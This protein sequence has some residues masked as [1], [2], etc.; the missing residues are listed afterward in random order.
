MKMDDYRS[1]KKSP[2][3]STLGLFAD[4]LTPE[5][6]AYE[7]TQE[8][9]TPKAFSM[10]VP[11]VTSTTAPPPGEETAVEEETSPATVTIYNETGRVITFFMDRN[12]GGSQSGWQKVNSKKYTLKAGGE[13]TLRQTEAIEVFYDTGKGQTDWVQLE[14]GEY[15]FY[16]E[17]GEIFLDYAAMEEE[18]TGSGWEKKDDAP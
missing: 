15:G 10:P 5:D 9:Q 16:E 3:K 8:S 7:M 11:L 17:E 14:S 18:N 6:K 13:V 4:I 2:K 12:A 1:Q